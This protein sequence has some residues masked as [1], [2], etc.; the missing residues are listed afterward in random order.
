MAQYETI[1]VEQRDAVTL[2]TLNRPQALNALNSQVLEDLV[3]AFAA[4]EA[5]DGQRCA[6]L[7]GSGD[8]AFAAGADI[9]ELGLPYSDPGMDGPVIE[10]AAQE[11]A[12]MLLLRSGGMV[13]QRDLVKEVAD[14]L[15]GSG[16]RDTGDGT[17][18]EDLDVS[19][20]VW[21]LLRRG[22]LWALVEEGHG[23]GFVTRVRLSEAGVR[24][25]HLA[26][27]LLALRPRMEH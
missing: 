25:A 23:P 1:T 7:M 14:V 20:S 12:L 11:A 9:I 10:A 26:L 13:D 6:V 27:R 21:D 16:W 18:P 2:I 19:R 3:A 22:E 4:F 5:D 15:A 24:G 17:P 8:K